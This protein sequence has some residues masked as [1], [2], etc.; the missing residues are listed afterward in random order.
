MGTGAWVSRYYVLCISPDYIMLELLKNSM[1]AT[2]DWHGVDAVDLP[3]IKVVIADGDDNE[4]V[5][6]KVS[7]EGGGIPRSNM[8]KIWS[9]LF[10]TA[11]P[12]V[13]EGMMALKSSN[14]V[15]HGVDSPLAGLGYGLPI[16]RS[17]CRYFGGDLSVM[18]MEGHGTD[19]FVYLRRLGSAREPLPI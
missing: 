17:Y 6:I 18:S 2:M 14:N 16:S 10:T 5:V 19:A 3:P 1:R 8:K 13:Q 15:D 9:Y 11:D 12:A 7:D 4:D